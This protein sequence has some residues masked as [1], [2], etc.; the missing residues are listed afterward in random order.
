MR[1]LRLPVH[2]YAHITYAYRVCVFFFLQLHMYVSICICQPPLTFIDFMCNHKWQRKITTHRNK[3]NDVKEK[4]W[5]VQYNIVA[6]HYKISTTLTGERLFYIVKQGGHFNKIC[7]SIYKFKF[8]SLLSYFLNGIFFSVVQILCN[9][10]R[11]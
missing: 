3:I 2:R 6:F 9:N 4:W 7:M 5:Q 11:C 10:N 8:L 1:S